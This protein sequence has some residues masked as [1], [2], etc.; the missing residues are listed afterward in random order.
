LVITL[1]ATRYRNSTEKELAIT[2][3]EFIL[4]PMFDANGIIENMW[5]TRIKK[6]APGG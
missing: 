2:V 3:N 4:N 5:L 6:G 1:T